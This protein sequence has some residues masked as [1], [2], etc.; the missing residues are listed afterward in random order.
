MNKKGTGK[1]TTGK[2]HPMPW[3]S[4]LRKKKQNEGPLR[5]VKGIPEG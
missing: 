3:P 5:G 4:S 1:K 2:R